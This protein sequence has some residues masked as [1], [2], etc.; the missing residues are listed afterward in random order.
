MSDIT[1]NILKCYDTVTMSKVTQNYND[2]YT[3]VSEVL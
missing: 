2:N 1:F 3:V